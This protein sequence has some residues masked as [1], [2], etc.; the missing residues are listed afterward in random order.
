[1][2]EYV[3]ECHCALVSLRELEDV[4]TCDKQ[5]KS[6]DEKIHRRQW[7]DGRSKLLGV[8]GFLSPFGDGDAGAWLRAFL[9]AMLR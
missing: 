4:A 2:A 6:A 7:R 5:R 3:V 8:F 9:A 1:L